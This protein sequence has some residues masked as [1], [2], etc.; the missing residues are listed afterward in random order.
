MTRP[1]FPGELDG[2]GYFYDPVPLPD[3]AARNLGTGTQTAHDDRYEIAE[4]FID[5]ALKLWEGSWDDD[6]TVRARA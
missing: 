2:R 5:V 3:S 1:P 6:A 4:E